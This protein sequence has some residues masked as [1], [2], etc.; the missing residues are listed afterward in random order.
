MVHLY[1]SYSQEKES[2]AAHTLLNRILEEQYGLEQPQLCL[3][4]QAKPF[5]LQ[6]PEFS[7]SHSWGH[8]AIAISERPVGVDV[9]LVRPYMERLPERIFSPGELT[10]FQ[11][12]YATKVDFF[13]LWTLKESYYKFKGT[14]LLGF[15]NDTEF[16]QD[17]QG[18]WR[19]GGSSLFFHVMEEKNLLLTLCC[20]EKEEIRIHRM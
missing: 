14:G 1:L 4:P 19:L 8:I 10:W 5:L 3:G 13:T 7:I 15:P 12:R 11:G 16:Y 20:Q 9:E 17:P 6:G 18:R 2:Q